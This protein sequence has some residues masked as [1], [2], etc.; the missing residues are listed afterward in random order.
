MTD[1]G[2]RLRRRH[3]TA[4]LALDVL[5]KLV[6]SDCA[7]EYLANAGVRCVYCGEGDARSPSAG[8]AHRA[9]CPIV[10]GRALI[11]ASDPPAPAG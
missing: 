7:G 8:V 1:S 2:Q 5:K 4:I 3:E 9:D 6:A 10:Q 11:A